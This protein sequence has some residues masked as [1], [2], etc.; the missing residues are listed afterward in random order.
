MAPSCKT[1]RMINIPKVTQF[2]RAGDGVQLKATI[3]D[4]VQFFHWATHCVTQLKT[5]VW[6]IS[7]VL[8]L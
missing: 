1:L 3:I 8:I 6:I 5:D 2:G 7:N 4:Y